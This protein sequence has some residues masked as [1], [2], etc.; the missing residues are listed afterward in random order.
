MSDSTSMTM[1]SNAIAIIGMSGRFPGARNL[2]EFWKNLCAGVES[3]SFFTDE[4]LRNAGVDLSVRQDPSYVGAGGVL[5]DIDLFDASFFGFNPREAEA[6]DPQHRLFLECAWEAMENAGYDATRCADPIGVYAGTGFSTYLFNVLENPELVDLLG[7]HQVMI[8]NDKDH[9]T[10]HVSYKFNLRGPSLAVQTA[11]STSLVAV[12]VAC[13]SLLD[14]QCD[15]AFA[16]GSSIA[17]PQG[18][19]Y[20]Y[21]EGGIASPDG[22][23]RAFDEKAR[24]T[25]AG[26]GVGC[27]LLKRYADALSDGDNVRAVIRGTAL[28]NDGAVKVGYTAPSVDGQ[29]EVIAMAHA[30]AEVSADTITYVEA[31]GTGTPLGD[32]IE[33]AA[34]AQAFQGVTGHN[35]CAVGSVKSN[36]GHLDTAA[37]IAG[38][39]KTVLALEHRVIPPTLHLESP[40]PKLEIE[41][42]PFF[43]NT[44]ARNWNPT[45][46]CRAGVSSFGIGGTNAHA[47]LEEAPRPTPADRSRPY[48]LL[49]LSAQTSS[50]LDTLSARYVEFF[51]SCSKDEL[52][53]AA[54]TSLLGRKAF[55]H[56]LALVCDGPL[57]AATQ[58]EMS[59]PGVFRGVADSGHRPVVF[60]FPGQGSQYL[61]M[62]AGLYRDEPAFR[63]VLNE[64]MEFL[65]SHCAVA[66]REALFP[67]SGGSDEAEAGLVET[68]I[69][70]PALFAVEYALA[71]TLISWGVVPEEMIGHSVGEY[72]AACLA[73]VFSPE[74]ALRLVAL[75]GK[76]MQSMAPGAMLAVSANAESIRPLLK[77]DLSLAAVNSPM[78]CVVSGSEEAVAAFE[79]AAARKGVACIRLNTSHAFHSSMMEPILPAFRDAIASAHPK[80]PSI[81]ILSNVTG[82]WLTDADAGDPQYWATHLRQ[83][84]QFSDG[85]EKILERPGAVLIEVGPGQALSRLSQGHP[86]KRSDV[87]IVA[88]MRRARESHD[89]FS[90]LLEALGRLWVCGVGVDWGAFYAR[91]RRRRIALPTYPFERKSYWVDRPLSRDKHPAPARQNSSDPADWLYGVGWKSVEVSEPHDKAETRKWLILTEGA[92]GDAIEAE[93]RR[94]GQRVVIVR[95]GN[96]FS[97]QTDENILARPQIESDYADLIRHLQ[98]M[99]MLPDEIL[100]CWTVPDL[101]S[102]EEQIDSGFHSLLF[103]ARALNK[104]APAHTARINMISTAT[105]CVLTDD[106]VEPCKATLIGPCAVIPQEQTGLRC[107]II[108]IGTQALDKAAIQIIENCRSSEMDPVI[109]YRG[110]RRWVRHYEPFRLPRESAGSP[111]LL[112]RHGVYVITGGFGNVGLTLAE[113]LARHFEA[114]LALLSRTQLPPPEAWRQWLATHDS[115]ESIS[116]RIRA[117]GELEG[118]G[119]EVL[120]VHCDVAQEHQFESALRKVQKVWGDLDGVIHAAAEMSGRVFQPV[121][122]SD[123]TNAA[124]HFGPKIAGTE[125]L[126][127]LSAEFEPG[128]CM[129]VSSLSSVLGG[130]NFAAYAA[131][132]AYLDAFVERQNQKTGNTRWFSVNWDGWSFDPVSS[133]GLAL[134]PAEGAEVFRRILQHASRTRII[135]SKTDLSARLNRWIRLDAGSV[136]NAAEAHVNSG[137]ERPTMSIA[138]AKPETAMEQLVV[139]VWQMILGIRN[140][141]IHDNFFELGGHSLLAIQ[142]ISRLRDLLQADISLTALFEF[143]TVA[144]LAAHIAG[145]LEDVAERVQGLSEMLDLVEGLSPDEVKALLAA[146]EER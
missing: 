31:H 106:L 108:D 141:G 75:R 120:V 126:G 137:H 79:S 68:S 143:P 127:R 54:F 76:L 129:L 118:L 110:G 55:K 121:A 99:G 50:A 83:C 116:R 48:H 102:V 87:V 27:V 70:Q 46:P 5:D 98:Q 35:R 115:E 78:Q 88:T 133:S 32:P 138:Y 136:E 104:C 16:G 20:F 94:A 89:D 86:A 18:R 132:N 128:F 62:A 114:R 28:N 9:L 52:A 25:V 42:T 39:I 93:L 142:L 34:L 41:R 131:A 7:T 45:G 105:H 56:R 111:S 74:E 36:I 1:T 69:A 30:V 12:S 53:D 57:Q 103:L 19:G 107:R 90:Y 11:C 58:L 123:R 130:L 65:Q 82:R 24:G 21:R 59:K 124:Q 38:L 63:E 33:F 100:H 109:A 43:I 47:V 10:T 91:E 6:M 139:D 4:Q 96:R 80:S 2:L 26:N 73:G 125:I 95:S 14:Y 117:V 49:V 66:L 60:L 3:V 97:V 23:C 37:G 17:V 81:P 40:N 64:C 8:G 135:V 13:R 140:I 113:T 51:R 72:V 144:Q 145:S 84:V 134:T 29:A 122:T 67:V 44:R 85:L 61:Q 77:R 146:E 15:M 22:H 119:A 71:R 112:R 92:L 101:H